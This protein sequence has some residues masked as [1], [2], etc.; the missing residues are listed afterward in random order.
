MSD[1]A[2]TSTFQEERA[3]LENV[4]ESLVRSPRL[5]KLLRF[6]G[7][8]Y[9]GG[10]QDQLKEYNIAVDLFGRP[11][12]RFHPS[13][14]AIARVEAHRLRKRLKEY[15][16]T[17]GR[18]HAVRISIPVGSYVPV[19][20]RHTAIEHSVIVPPEA[21]VPQPP[22]AEIGPATLKPARHALLF[23]VL[24]TAP[25][26]LGLSAL[27]FRVHVVHTS[28]PAAASPKLARTDTGVLSTASAPVPLRMIAGYTGPTRLD[29]FGNQWLSDQYFSGGRPI[30][31]QTVTTLRTN[32]AMLFRQGRNGEFSYNIPLRPGTYELHLYFVASHPLQEVDTEH[33]D[34]FSVFIND[35]LVLSNFDIESDALGTDTAD[36][37][38]FKDV[39][40][41][42]DGRLHVRFQGEQ[43][44]PFLNAIEVLPG[45]TNE[46]LPI[47]V[48]VQ[49]TPYTDHAGNFWEPDDYYA[50]GRVSR[51]LHTVSSTSDPSLF[52]YER[53]GHFT[54]AIPVDQHGTYTL[55]L[56]F[57]EFYFGPN[58]PGGG[59][60]GSRIFNVM[61]NG[62]LLLKHFDIYGEAGALHSVTKTFHHL[63]PTA[64]GKLNLTF[65]PVVN[66][67][68]ISGIEV[69]DESQ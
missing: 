5:E 15:Y 27:L 30:A 20:S 8:K 49:P 36:E 48:A 43:S 62:V 51:A 39:H 4:A 44:L 17:E 63:E 35:K 41:A 52:S 16:E 25:I 69:L 18:D 26:L 47:R 7:E 37:R 53:Y 28:Q 50:G 67:A 21:P 22:V 46:Q 3:E 66:N 68:T 32:R 40:P 34:S 24:A 60:N 6:M 55:M 59:G 45:I 14:D 38:V 64:Q 23:W 1:S 61:C 42:P 10:D 58:S 56:H 19:F 13:N 9:F 31:R 54:Y 57:T 11:A 2:V 33:S 29:S 12:S 65:E